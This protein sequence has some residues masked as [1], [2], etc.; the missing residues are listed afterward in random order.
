MLCAGQAITL[1]T[2]LGSPRQPRQPPTRDSAQQLDS[3]TAGPD[4][5]DS[6]PHG[7]PST[8]QFTCDGVT[9]VGL[10]SQ[11][12]PTQSTDGDGSTGMSTGDDGG[13]LLELSE[14]S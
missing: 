10:K 7:S 1:N 4:S 2:A 9:S 12:L 6:S 3:S 11:S 5:L 8:Q 13:E 14:A